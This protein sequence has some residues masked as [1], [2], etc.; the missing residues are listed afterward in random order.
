MSKGAGF[1]QPSLGTATTGGGA[2]GTRT[3]GGFGNT[4]GLGG[5]G[6][7]TV[8]GNTN[9]QQSTTRLSHTAEL[10]FPVKPI[11][12]PA[13][14]ADVQAMLARSS[15]VSSAASVKVEV[16]GNLIVLR[17]RV[18]DADEKRLVEGM[19]RLSPGVRDVKNELEHP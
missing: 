9:N 12:M 5:R 3:T 4:G 13:L 19:V 16:S 6:N 7:A 17:G 14:V 1:G 10:K 15:M 8:G 2:A 11:E 18:A